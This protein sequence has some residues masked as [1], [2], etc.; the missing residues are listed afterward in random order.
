MEE[1]RDI[2]GFER[3]QVSDLGRVRSIGQYGYKILKQQNRPKL[4]SIKNRFGLPG[5][6]IKVKGYRAVA[7]DGRMK[8]VH[9]L[10][11][12]AFR[13]PRPPGF[14][15]CHR[16]DD[17]HNN[18]LD[19]LRWDTPESNREDERQNRSRPPR[20][21]DRPLPPREII[22]GYVCGMAGLV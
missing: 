2:P 7:L 20:R 16:D 22:S 15:A 10:V 13:G 1:W 21:W 8:M 9:V 18:K 14:Q 12:L 6:I 4:K 19:N 3:Y 11:L 17:G 5:R